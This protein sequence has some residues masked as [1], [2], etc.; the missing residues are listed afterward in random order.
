VNDLLAKDFDITFLQVFVD[1]INVRQLTVKIYIKLGSGFVSTAVAY[2]MRQKAIYHTCTA[3]G[4]D[5][6][7]A[8]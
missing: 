6:V 1:M 8:V 3:E 7:Q 4:K 2:K 5:T